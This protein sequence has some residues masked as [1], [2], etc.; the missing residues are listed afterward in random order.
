MPPGP[1]G[2]PVRGA[3]ESSLSPENKHDEVPWFW[4]MFKGFSKPVD[5]F[6]V[7]GIPT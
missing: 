1:F 6:R 5:A 7:V 4:S 3:P 2:P